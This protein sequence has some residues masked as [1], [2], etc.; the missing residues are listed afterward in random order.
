[1]FREIDDHLVNVVDFGRGDPTVLG[2]SG[3]IGNWEMWQQP[4][5]RLSRRRRVVAY[6]HHGAGETRGSI[7]ALSFDSQV[8][9]VFGVM[10]ALEIENCVIAGESNGGAVAIEA[11]LRDPS[12]FRALILVAGAYTGFD[13]PITRAFS[14]QLSKDFDGVLG[15]FIDLCTPEPDVEHI[16]RWLGHIL[17][18]AEPEAAV[19][20]IESMYKVDLKPRLDEISLPTL[21]IHGENDSMPS[22]RLSLAEEAARLIA[23]S[24]LE[25]LEATGHVPTLT[26]P[27]RVAA[28]MDRFIERL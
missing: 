27:E 2:V 28:A 12:R 15:P 24:E 4:F 10:D 26:R 21:I 25:V 8:D 17:R 9:A 18:R 1:V 3:W 19:G 7:D 13:V 16:R 23:E 14:E 5:E 6:D 11:L 22:T 20:L